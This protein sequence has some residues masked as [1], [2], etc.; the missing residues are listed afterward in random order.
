MK[1]IERRI[2]RAAE[3]L[4]AERG[5]DVTWADIASASDLTPTVLRRYFRNKSLLVD[6]V[7]ARLFA[8]RWRP[9]WQALLAN[10]AAPL[11]RR[12]IRFY[13]E[14]RTH[15]HR[16]STRLWIRA[17][18]AG[19]HASGKYAYG[20][21][22]ARR[23][24]VPIVRELRRE[25]GL[26]SPEERP[27][28][29]GELELVQML[30]GSVGFPNSRMHVFDL[31]VHGNLAEIVAMMVRV[32]LTG[33]RTELRRLHSVRV[34]LEAAEQSAADVPTAATPEVAPE[35]DTNVRRA[36]VELAEAV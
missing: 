6:K 18:L 31:P 35:P 22:L 23:I 12:L 19:L 25:Q 28:G 29:A 36:E 9:E 4:F 5:F 16:T 11:E 8:G 27:I 32:W 10:R 13:T 7:V 17:G 20:G 3:A 33:A 34:A 24:L 2:V 15:T 14:Y 26:A 1:E 21:I 30:H